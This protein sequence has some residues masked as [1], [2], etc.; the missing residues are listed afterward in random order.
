MRPDNPGARVMPNQDFNGL[1]IGMG[2]QIEIVG[3]RE[4]DGLLHPLVFG[5][6]S[7]QMKFADASV[8]A[9][10]EYV[11]RQFKDNGIVELAAAVL[12]DT[13][14]RYKRADCQPARLGAD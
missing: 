5:R 12:Q 2:M 1:L 11:M 6:F 9:S 8:I 7:R 3:D 4:V 14:G 10:F 13:E